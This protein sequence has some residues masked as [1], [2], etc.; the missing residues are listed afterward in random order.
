MK[1]FPKEIKLALYN[2]QNGICKNCLK[3]IDKKFGFHHRLL[4]NKPNHAKFKHFINSPMNLY[5]FMFFLPRKES[6]H[7]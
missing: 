5:W 1:T 2:A 7:V 4:N 6:S 3:P